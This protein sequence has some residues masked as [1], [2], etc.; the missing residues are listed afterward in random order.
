MPAEHRFD[1]STRLMTTR[2]WGDISDDDILGLARTIAEDPNIGPGTR[3]ILDLRE[4]ER[5]TVTRDALRAAADINLSHPDKFKGNRTAIVAT[6]DAHYGLAKM[7][8]HLMAA[9]EAPTRVRVFRTIEEAR[10][11]LSLSTAAPPPTPRPPADTP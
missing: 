7:Y 5:A 11:W 2:L 8:S 4:V 10:E 1:E 9:M 6:R 3:E